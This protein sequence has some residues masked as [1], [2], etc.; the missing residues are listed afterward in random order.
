M[1]AGRSPFLR[2]DS[3]DNGKHRGKDETEQVKVSTNKEIL[4]E[5]AALFKMVGN[6]DHVMLGKAFLL[7][8]ECDS[9]AER[10]RYCD[11]VGLAF[12]TMREILALTR[13]LD[14]SLTTLGFQRTT[15]CNKNDSSWRIVRSVLVAAL[16]PTQV[17][18]VQRPSAKYTEVK[19][20]QSAM[21]SMHHSYFFLR[22][23]C[24]PPSNCVWID[25]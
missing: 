10:K 16:S 1:S 15:V 17:V 4:E 8:K 22:H 12:N 5:R 21:S 19:Y 2:I 11:R 6:S 13:Q 14:S 7:W 18:R 9:A 3:F 20:Y 25:S 24:L 23:Q